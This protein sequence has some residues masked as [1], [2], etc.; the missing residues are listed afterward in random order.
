MTSMTTDQL[1]AMIGQIRDK[2]IDSQD[3]VAMAFKFLGL[4]ISQ[5][6][7]PYSISNFFAKYEIDGGFREALKENNFVIKY[8]TDGIVTLS[9]K[10]SDGYW[11]FDFKDGKGEKRPKLTLSF[12]VAGFIG[13]AERGIVFKPNVVGTGVSPIDFYPQY[14]VFETVAKF[15][16]EAS[17]IIKDTVEGNGQLVVG[18]DKIKLGG[19]RSLDQLFKEFAASKSGIESL[20]VSSVSPFNP[21]PSLIWLPEPN[22]PTLF[23]IWAE[24][25]KSFRN[26]L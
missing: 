6:L 13:K 23:K 10:A 7:S 22:Q 19:I 2:L 14:R 25:L 16:A 15:D 18:W 11:N 3:L 24:Q 21:S 17:Q 12:G 1:R 8:R 5:T 9:D 4:E 20:A 26:S